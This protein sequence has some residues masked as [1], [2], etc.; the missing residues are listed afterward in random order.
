MFGYGR[1]NDGG[2]SVVFNLPP[3]HKDDIFEIELNVDFDKNNLPRYD[4]D[5]KCPLCF[6]TFIY[7]EKAWKEAKQKKSRINLNS[8]TTFWY[9]IEKEE[10][11]N[12]EC[13][14][15]VI[16]MERLDCGE[17][18]VIEVETF[19]PCFCFKHPCHIKRVSH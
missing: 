11:Q 7:K 1:V 13:K 9:N 19:E 10:N 5:D 6:G 3:V 12:N 4:D 2:N 8:R 15:Q 16:T 14:K 18:I 17:N